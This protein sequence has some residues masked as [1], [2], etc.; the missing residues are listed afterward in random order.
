M[1][2]STGLII[3]SC[4]LADHDSQLSNLSIPVVR[5]PRV[6]GSFLSH[7]CLSSVY[8]MRVHSLCFI[9]ICR[10]D[11]SSTDSYYLLLH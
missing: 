8:A 2:V 3:D 1:L 10:N 9:S 5:N 7:G 6:C 11:V 4:K